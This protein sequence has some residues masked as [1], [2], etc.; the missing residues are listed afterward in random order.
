MKGVQ[1]D[2]NLNRKKKILY[3]YSRKAQVKKN[4]PDM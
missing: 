1:L 4:R 2:R 3:A